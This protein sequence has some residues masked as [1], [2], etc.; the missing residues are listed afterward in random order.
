MIS[1]RWK[2]SI[3]PK[4]RWLWKQ[5]CEKLIMTHLNEEF[6]WFMLNH[7]CSNTDQ[8]SIDYCSIVHFGCTYWRGKELKKFSIYFQDVLQIAIAIS[9][10]IML[11]LHQNVSN[12]MLFIEENYS[13]PSSIN[14]LIDQHLKLRGKNLPRQP[15]LTN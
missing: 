7:T 2:I 9:A 3:Y 13:A 12:T 5:Q 10:S 1:T 11:I 8:I 15:N 6:T 4:Y 14:L